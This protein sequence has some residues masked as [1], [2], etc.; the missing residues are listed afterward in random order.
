[1]TTPKCRWPSNTAGSKNRPTRTGY[2]KWPA[3]LTAAERRNPQAVAAAQQHIVNQRRDL[4]LRLAALCGLT[5][6]EWE[7]RRQKIQARLESIADAANCRQ[8]LRE[9]ARITANSDDLSNT[10][11]I[12]LAGRSIAG[13]LFAT[14]QLF[15]NPRITVAEELD[16][17][18]ICTDLSLQSVAEIETHPELYPGVK[19]QPVYRRD[20]PEGQLAAHL[21][22]YLAAAG[23]D[24]IPKKPAAAVDDIADPYQPDDRIG[25]AG[26]ERQYESILRAHRGITIDRVDAR[27]QTIETK[28]LRDPTPGRDLMLTVDPA[29]QRRRKPYSTRQSPAGSPLK[30]PPL[31]AS[32][33][34]VIMVLDCHSGA[35]LA[36]ASWPRYNPNIFVEGDRS[37]IQRM[38][39]NPAHPLF[40]RAVQM[41]LPPG[42]VFKIVS[43]CALLD[44]G[45]DPRS[46]VDCEG[47]LHQPDALRCAI[48]KQYGIGHGPVT[49]ADV[50]AR[51]CNV[52][53]FHHASS[54][55]AAI[56][57]LGSASGL[58][59]AN[60][61]RS[62]QRSCR[63]TA[64]NTFNQR[65]CLPRPIH[66]TGATRSAAAGHWPSGLRGHAT[67]NGARSWPQ[68]P[69]ADSW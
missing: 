45:V 32:C 9:E 54:W 65:R 26:L 40:D 4:A 58:G 31:D 21:L 60:E 51:S 36:S 69:T 59:H 14:D 56:Y 46:P 17:H 5:D 10:S 38:L 47:Y 20:Y 41:A 35:I 57:R 13:A 34:G 67:A 63:I 12:A 43:A 49:L 28:T 64:K 29:V 50:L 68:L 39:N 25:R 2:V 23:P 22:G 62:S 48:F 33:G 55:P 27:G 18:V 19:L 44:H 53:F 16:A 8:Q 42:S 1:M 37:Q 30:T 11:F 6:S 15:H 3:Q 61:R 7:A 66:R 52:Y 24:D